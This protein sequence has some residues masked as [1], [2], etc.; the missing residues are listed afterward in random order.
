MLEPL[1]AYETG[2]RAR[3]SRG[4]TTIDGRVAVWRAI[5]PRGAA[6]RRARR[7]DAREG[8]T[9]TR[10][11]DDRIVNDDGD[12]DELRDHGASGRGAG[13]ARDARADG[14][15]PL[16]FFALGRGDEDVGL[17]HAGDFE[18]SLVAGFLERGRR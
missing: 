18:R 12:R 8:S 13:R 4:M 5:D 2:S 9:T 15:E 1:S 14:G 3:V 16:V 11:D 6:R 7:R 10:D 17:A